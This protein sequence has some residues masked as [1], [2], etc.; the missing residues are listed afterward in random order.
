VCLVGLETA[1]VVVL[2]TVLVVLMICVG[3][4]LLQIQSQIVSTIK[5]KPSGHHDYIPPGEMQRIN[6]EFME[7]INRFKR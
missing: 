3:N 6:D 7:L 5:A 2:I 4:Q 1:L